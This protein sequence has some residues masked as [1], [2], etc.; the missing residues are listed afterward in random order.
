MMNTGFW[1]TRIFPI[2]AA[3]ALFLP[4]L[5]LAQPLSE[6]DYATWGILSTEVAIPTGSI[7][8]NAVLTVKG[9]SP[10]EA[11]CEVYLLDNPAPGYTRLQK[12]DG[13]DSTFIG[14]G[15]RL[16]GVPQEGTLV[17]HFTARENDDDQSWVWNVFPN[18][19]ILLFPKQRSVSYTSALLELMDYAGTGVSFGIGIESTENKPLEFTEI[20]L[21]ITFS[22]YHNPSADKT[23]SFSCTSNTSDT[24]VQ[25]N[26]T[27][28]KRSEK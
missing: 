16:I 2:K 9:V 18:P 20:E 26:P 5:T 13:S 23:V 19:F 24:T 12:E 22:S 14:F 27:V 21:T 11:A 10:S 17:Y 3:V 28:V 6:T 25:K 4:A 7:I 1:N 15:T 8:S